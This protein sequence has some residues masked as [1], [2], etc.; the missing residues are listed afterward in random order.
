[1]RNKIKQLLNKE[2]GFT[3][4]ELLAVLAIL[5]LIVGIAIPMIGN[6]VSNSQTKADAAQSE[7]IVNAAQLQAVEAG[8]KFDA[9]KAIDIDPLVNAGYLESDPELKGKTLTVT[10]GTDGKKVYTLSTTS[11]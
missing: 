2:E 8:T 11:P 4:V 6:V 5:A 3:L 10:T 1:M 7:L 9:S